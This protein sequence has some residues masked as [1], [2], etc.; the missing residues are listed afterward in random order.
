MLFTIHDIFCILSHGAMVLSGSWMRNSDRIRQ[1]WLKVPD[2][3]LALHV[4]VHNAILPLVRVTSIQARSVI[5][6]RPNDRPSILRWWDLRLRCVRA[7][8]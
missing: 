3:H 6:A 7:R 2:Y 8:V 5:S 1:F 4:F